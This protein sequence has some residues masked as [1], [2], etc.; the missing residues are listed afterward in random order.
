M[1]QGAQNAQAALDSI[2]PNGVRNSQQIATRIPSFVSFHGAI[3][4]QGVGHGLSH[5]KKFS[6][7]FQR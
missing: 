4:K 7:Y 5:G 1:T 6:K 3:L 2:R